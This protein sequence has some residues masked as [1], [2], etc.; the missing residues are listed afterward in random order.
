MR[1][2][3]SQRATSYTWVTSEFNTYYIVLD[4]AR[5]GQIMNWDSET[6]KFTPCFKSKSQFTEKDI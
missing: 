6:L 1:S 4:Y 3:K 2:L 5:Y